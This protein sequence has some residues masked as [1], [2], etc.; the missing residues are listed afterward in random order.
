LNRDH[1]KIWEDL[2]SA[3]KNCRVKVIK[4]NLDIQDHWEQAEKEKWRKAFRKK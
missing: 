4:V 3:N 1:V 2:A